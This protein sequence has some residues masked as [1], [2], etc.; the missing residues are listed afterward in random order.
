MTKSEAL[1]EILLDDETEELSEILEKFSIRQRLRP[2]PQGE[3]VLLGVDQD[4]KDAALILKLVEN[5]QL[6]TI[7]PTRDR[8]KDRL[9]LSGKNRISIDEENELALRVQKYNDIDARNCLVMSNIG[10]VHLVANQFCRPP[11]RYEDLVQEGTM[12]LLRATETFEPGR[13]VRFST[14]SV[15]W[16]RAKIQRHL[17]RIDRDDVPIITGAD[18]FEDD[19]G[20]RRRPRARKISIEHSQE[21]DSL[22]NL[23]EIIPS[24]TKDPEKVALGVERDRVI[25]EVLNG[26]VDELG[27]E[28][29][30]TV[31][32]LRLLTDEPQTLSYV[33]EKLNLSREGARL[34]EAKLLKLA[35]QRLKKWRKTI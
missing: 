5:G 2:G 32:E 23:S 34:L 30:K 8:S 17:Q 26:L 35:K 19:L 21:D 7:L 29:L 12:G 6:D 33:G 20:K 27:D 16:I 14:Y 28:R 25:S 1:P 31:I 3:D 22:R 10:L 11:V 24:D 18:M 4:L 13:G 9:Y 15:Y